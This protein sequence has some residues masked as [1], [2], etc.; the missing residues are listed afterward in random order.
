MAVAGC[1]R[2]RSPLQRYF[3]HEK[4]PPPKD[5]HRSLCIGLLWGPGGGDV[6]FER[7]YPVSALK[8]ISPTISPTSSSTQALYVLVVGLGF[9]GWGL[10][11]RVCRI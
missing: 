11:G 9:M 7:D 2:E 5:H 1:V 3:A 4:H 6:S 8:G 10:G